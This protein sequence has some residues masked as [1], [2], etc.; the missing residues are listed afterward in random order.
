MSENIIKNEMFNKNSNFEEV[1]ENYNDACKSVCKIIP[2]DIENS[3]SGFLIKLYKDQKELLCLMTC[4][5]VI[6]EDMIES[7]RIIDVKF[8]NDKEPREI[9]LDKKERYIIYDKEKDFTLVEILPNNLINREYFLLPNTNNINIKN[10]DIYILQF[11]ESLSLKKSE[12]KIIQIDDFYFLYDASTK[13]G[14]SGSPIFLKNST[15]VIGMHKGG[16]ALFKENYGIS[17]KTILEAL[18]PEKKEKKLIIDNIKEIGGKKGYYIGQILNGKKEGKG[19]IFDMNNNIIYEGYF[20]NDKYEGD[21]RLNY[22]NGEYYIGQFLNGLRHGNGILFYNS[23]LIKYEGGFVKDKFEG[24]GKCSIENGEYYEGQWY[25]GLRHGKGTYYYSNGTIKYK[26]DFV[27]GKS[28]GKGKY[29]WKNG[30][31]Y[32]GQFYKGERH[33]KGT[34]YNK[35]GDIIYEGEYVNGRREGKNAKNY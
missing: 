19:K 13:G 1:D 21:G 18:N 35:N 33:G 34:L 30:V 4:E 10:A 6:T 32:E 7:K 22:E 17:I 2:K 9:K 20:Y 16:D 23:D 12:G 5:H 29:V 27:N 26:G 3:G 28:E 24:Y 8:R 11:P 14:S 31:Y 25:N 15:E